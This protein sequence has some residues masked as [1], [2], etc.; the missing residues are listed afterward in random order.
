MTISINGKTITKIS[1]PQKALAGLKNV[2]PIN[3]FDF[4]RQTLGPIIIEQF[5]KQGKE[6][7]E[8]YLDAPAK[9]RLM[10]MSPSLKERVE[11]GE[12]IDQILAGDPLELSLFLKEDGSLYIF[13]DEQNIVL[14]KKS[15]EEDKNKTDI[16][17]TFITPPPQLEK[18]AP[19]EKIKENSTETGSGINAWRKLKI[20]GLE[21]IAK[22]W[23]RIIP[24]C[25]GFNYTKWQ[26]FHM[27]FESQLDS[28]ISAIS[29][30]FKKH[31]KKTTRRMFKA[32]ATPKLH[33]VIETYGIIPFI[34]IMK[35]TNDIDAFFKRI[36][37]IIKAY[38]ECKFL[39]KSVEDFNLFLELSGRESELSSVLFWA[40]KEKRNANRN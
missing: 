25:F 23:F 5:K 37:K 14:L 18:I 1:I 39:I 15:G 31:G 11:A 8:I 33:K 35:S 12:R 40:V 13:F 21:G 6:I 19:E 10:G 34:E 9:V 20:M 28:N 36:K 17:P 29:E 24:E 22:K 3:S 7:E 38:P 27:L 32:I 30:V 16:S 26:M 2:K 4:G